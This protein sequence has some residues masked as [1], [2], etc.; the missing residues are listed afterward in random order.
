MSWRVLLQRAPLWL[1]LSCVLLLLSL[2][3]WSSKPYLL[4]MGVLL[5]LAVIQGQAWNVIG[6]YAGQHSLGHAAYFG[7]GAY[8]TVMLLELQHVPPY[9]GI[10]AGVLIAVAVS[11][12]IGSITFRL[13]GPYFVLASISVAEI[14]RLA[15]LHFKGFTRGAEGILVSD[16]PA[17]KFAGL[18]IDFLSKRPFYYAALSVALLT[19]AMSW[20]VRHS[21]LGYYL[22]AIRE[23]QD[24]AHSIGINLQAYKNIA[25]AISAAFTAW[26]GGFYALFVKFIDPDTVFGLDVSVQILLVCIVGGIGTIAGPVLGA[27]LLV[28][29][30]EIL[31][32]PKG[33]VQLGLVASDSSVV[34][35]IEQRFSNAHD[36]V[37]GLL[38]VV[39][40]LFAPEGLLGVLRKLVPLPAAGSREV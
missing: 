19:T 23:D 27:L 32:N 9:W 40:I 28:P 33:L 31:R 12:L 21:K 39:I 25:L 14:I 5:F 17:L 26:A 29:L 10:C 6:G 34:Q 22:Q 30:S 8:A 16:I 13:R 18:E 20:A 24:A 7:L 38:L 1:G 3:V 37:Y 2:P 4:H 15:A 11:L 36:F 35:L